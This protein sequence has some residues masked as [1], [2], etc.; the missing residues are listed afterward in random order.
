MNKN[1]RVQ[2]NMRDQVIAL[3]S[4][5]SAAII[6]QMPLFPVWYA[7]FND[8]MAAFNL[9][10][11][12][13]EANRKGFHV[14]K[15]VIRFNLTE[16]ALEL[17]SIIQSYATGTENNP[18]YVSMA[19]TKSNLDRLGGT[20][21]V[22]ACR[23][24]SAT[25]TANLAALVDYNVNALK[26]TN[27]EALIAIMVAANVKPEEGILSKKLST[28]EIAVA[29]RESREYL[30]KMD[31]VV[32]TIKRAELL[33]TKAYFFARKLNHLPTTILSVRGSVKNA[34]GE[35]MP[36]VQITCA[37]LNLDRKA[38]GKGGFTLKNGEPGIHHITFFFPGFVTV[39][40]EVTIWSGLRAEVN[41][42]MHPHV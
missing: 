38:T 25:T 35:V 18:L 34:A 41:V 9:N 31:G 2:V 32:R 4:V 7:L 29:M 8:I 12:N 22:S 28:E 24:I 19:Y 3:I 14:D 39:T 15:R 33:F 6:A 13:Q 11:D 37:S 36:F 21:F 42:T 17:S 26:V 27:F 1:Q 23:R 40:Q 20:E 5:T 16:F 30:L 10:L